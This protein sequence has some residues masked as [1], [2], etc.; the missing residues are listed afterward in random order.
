MVKRDFTSAAEKKTKSV[1]YRAIIKVIP[2]RIEKKMCK[3]K[4][5]FVF[6]LQSQ[7]QYSASLMIYVGPP[8]EDKS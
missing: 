3:S 4:I 6:A 7:N 8:E 2:V 1:G 5:Q